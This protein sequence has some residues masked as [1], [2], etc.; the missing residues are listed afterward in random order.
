MKDI[1]RDLAK[2]RAVLAAHQESQQTTADQQHQSQHSAAASSDLSNWPLATT[3]YSC[4]MRTKG[5]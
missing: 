5:V 4:I 2:D 1:A 3:H